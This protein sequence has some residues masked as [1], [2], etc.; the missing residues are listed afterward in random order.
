MKLQLK[1][2]APYLPYKLKVAWKNIENNYA[3]AE[4]GIT[5]K[6]Q[7][8]IDDILDE[9]MCMKPILQPAPFKNMASRDYTYNEWSFFFEQHFDVFELIPKGLAIDINELKK[10]SDENKAQPIRGEWTT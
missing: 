1:H 2:L 7:G 10:A 6:E 9:D 8:W 4:M 5:E 3:T